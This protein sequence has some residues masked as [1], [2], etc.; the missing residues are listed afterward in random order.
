MKHKCY[1]AGQISGLDSEEYINN[2]EKA[3]QEVVALG[4]EPISP[5]DLEHGNS[6]S[7][8]DYMKLDLKALID[9]DYIYMLNNWNNSRGAKIELRIA[10][11]LKIETIMQK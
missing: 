3:K 8:E 1:I 11:D 7:W 4:Y 9:C 10:M 6:E 2:F 5:L